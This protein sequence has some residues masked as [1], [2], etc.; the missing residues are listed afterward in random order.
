MQDKNREMARRIAAEV[1][2]QGGRVYY[3]GG[4]VRD[5]LLGRESKDIDIEVHGVTP[6]ALCA[7]LDS[8]G[9]RTQMGAS[10]GV[11]GLR[12]YELDIAM[13]RL[14]SAT[15][16]GHKDFEIDTDPF[17]GV[18]KAAQRRDFT[19]NA[20]MEDVLTG[21]I[22]DS[23]GGLADLKAGI[24]RH[25]SA[26][27]FPEDPLRVLRAAQFAARFG[28]TVA[29]ETVALCR[30]MDL[31]ALAGERVFG[32]LRK[33]LLKAPE[34]SVFFETLREMDQLHAFFPEVEA[35]IGVRQEPRF[36]PEGDVFTHTMLVLNAAAAL[37]EQAREPLSFM[38]SALCHDFGK[39]GTTSVID[40]RIRSFGHEEAGVPLAE[41]FLARLTSEARLRR[42]VCGMVRLHM[43]PRALYRQQAGEKALCR[44]FD[45]S[46]C[47]EDLL[48]LSRADCLGRAQCADDGAAEQALRAGLARYREL[49]ARPH[50]TGADLVAAGFT[51]GP[52]FGEA[53][54]LAHK[55]R[56]AGVTREDALRQTTAFL[57]RRPEAARQPL[58]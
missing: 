53:L 6:Q 48:L 51:P 42:H 40:G 58:P 57:R 50:V 5:R 4:L 35:L 55:L 8:L 38:L 24:L 31:T 36:H 19:V 27:S 7:I 29:S 56:L 2:R 37:R 1:A 54:A 14:E 32:E 3:V 10:F 20:M 16:R 41:R 13:P 45:A 49:M 52:D 21:E 28:F 17:L 12:H 11:Y 23:F 34:P 15:G 9:E 18:F 30:T 43:R 47:P 44:L 22:V 25:V 26:Q 33:A 46:E 39:V